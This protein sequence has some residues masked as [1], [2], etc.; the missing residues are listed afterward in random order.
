MG[1]T[2]YITGDTYDLRNALKRGGWRWDKEAKAWTASY[3]EEVTAEEIVSELRRTDGIRNRVGRLS[4]EV[5][6]D[7]DS[8]TE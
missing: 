8:R 5:R 6:R 3:E 1:T 7:V 4:V 2:V